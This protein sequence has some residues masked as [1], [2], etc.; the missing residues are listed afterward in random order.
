MGATSW[1][2]YTPYQPIPEAALQ[3]LRAE[4]FAR[5]EYVDPTGPLDDLLRRTARRFGQD[6]DSPE[7]R[8]QIENDL[9]V[10]G[11]VETGGTSGLSPGDRALARRVREFRRLASRFGA[12]PPRRPS[13][14]PRSIEELLEWAAECG[15]HSVLD[16]EHVG[17]RPGFAVASPMTA[18][19]LRGVFGTTQPTHAQVEEHWADV[20]ERLGRWQARYLTVYLDGQPHE[21]GFIGCSGD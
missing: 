19:S 10:Q 14:R 6:P 1:R 2:Y 17:P 9:R 4:V 3:A 21:Y 7:V 11:A 12:E 16:I 20:A 8:R 18:A 15:T 5:G 13:R